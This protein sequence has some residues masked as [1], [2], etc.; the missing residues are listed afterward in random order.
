MKDTK[1]YS[2]M[3]VYK[4]K[5]INFGRCLGYAMN[6]LNGGAWG[7][8]TGSYLMFFMTTYGGLSALEVG[9]MFFTCK[10]LDILVCAIIGGVSD[11]LFKFKIGRLLGRRH[12]LM[13]VGAL[14]IVIGFPLLFQTS[15]GGYWWYFIIYFLIDSANAFIGIAYE[16]LPTEMTPK[17][18]ER[19][20][21]SSVRL[22]VSAFST[23]AVTA[24]PA[25][26][27]S[28]LP[29]DGSGHGS[30]MAYTISGCVFG[31]IFATGTL[32]TY[33]T[34]WEFSPKYV[35]E[36][37]IT[38]RSTKRLHVGLWT[39]ILVTLK[40]YWN[41]WKTKSC[42]RIF[43]IYFVSYFAKDCW[44][45]AFL[46]FIVFVLGLSQAHGQSVLSLSFI[47]MIVVPIATF[48]MIK[49]GPKFLWTTAYS[50]MLAVLIG[51]M[52]IFALERFGMIGKSV[53]NDGFKWIVTVFILGIC[54]QVGRQ[55]MEYTPWNVIPFVPDVDTLVS[56]KLRAGTFAA[57]QTF[58]R[59][60]TGALGTAF[61]GVVLE[62]S[63][64]VSKAD[65]QTSGAKWGII[66]VFAIIPFLLLLWCMYLIR[67]FNLN[68]KTHGIIKAEIDR[69][70]A[71]GSKMDV[72]PETR[73]VAE[74]LTGYK[75]DQLW[76]PDK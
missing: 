25:L 26:L 22:F 15:P 23:F 73:K 56:T 4:P 18:E 46:Y 43:T 17:A 34:T 21:L 28:I 8:L 55:I 72:D 12:A 54:W 69:L 63:G 5:K 35:E 61:I 62:W 2:K 10:M 29:D 51:F 3:R 32:I 47:G 6:D 38:N 48:L 19:V 74:D 31:V 66:T 60:A 20:K 39:N 36:F 76:D 13:L 37:E 75:Y 59:R 14:M 11:N 16:T 49:K 45:T 58:T 42:R 65:V 53:E 27:L 52:S 57:V 70:Q 30:S 1:D 40:E 7:T 9:G 44:A 71:G 50:I 33:F 24:L 41:V 64:F 68:Q 67:T